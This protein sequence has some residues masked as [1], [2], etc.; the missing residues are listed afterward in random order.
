M[1]ISPKNKILEKDIN[2]KI[3]LQICQKSEELKKIFEK[4]YLYIFQKY[5]YTLKNDENEIN[6]DGI[7]IIL[8]SKTKPFY[9]LLK[10]NEIIKEKFI[11]V[12]NDVY[13]SDKNYLMDKKFRI[14]NSDK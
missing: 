1:N 5:Y 10:K 6:L 9:H 7:K 13:F 3:F 14:I 12:V 4:K 2:K 8:S 11:N